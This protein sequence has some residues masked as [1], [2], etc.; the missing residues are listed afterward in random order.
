MPQSVI[1][2][3]PRML[4]LQGNSANLKKHIDVPAVDVQTNILQAQRSKHAAT[5]PVSTM[6]QLPVWINSAGESPEVC[7]A[8]AED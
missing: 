6:A 7:L 1:G 5:N 2:N 3:K 8:H 4:L